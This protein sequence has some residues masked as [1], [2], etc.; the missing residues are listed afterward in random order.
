MPKVCKIISLRQSVLKS[1]HL[2]SNHCTVPKKRQLQ[3]KI[4]FVH[5]IETAK[6]IIKRFK[7]IIEESNKISKLLARKV[8]IKGGKTNENIEELF[9]SFLQKYQ[10]GLEESMKGHEFIFDSVDVLC[11]DLNKISLN[12]GGS[13]I[14][15]PE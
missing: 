11:Y 10:E 3:K 2:R 14:D 15:S 8:G 6:P 9:K 12:R 1:S 7:P 13:Y 4:V 5:S